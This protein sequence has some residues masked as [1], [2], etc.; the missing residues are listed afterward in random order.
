MGALLSGVLPLAV[1]AAVS[2]SLFALQ[3]MVLSG[4]QRRVSRAWAVVV[5]A[6]ATLAFYAALGLTVLENFGGHRRHSSLAAAVDLAAAL[7]LA[8]LAARM[9][10]RHPTAGEVQRRRSGSRLA[11]ASTISC[12]GIGAAAMLVNFSTLVLFLPA[13]REISHSPVGLAQKSLVTLVLVIVTL[14]AAWLP[15]AL[16]V[17]FGRRADPL[18]SGLNRFVG[19]HSRE[20]TAGIELIFCGLLL[21]KAIGRLS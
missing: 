3:V 11:D 20:I 16:V 2:P 7:L 18:L 13:I 15:L 9:L 10:Y 4:S 1:G 19:A 14:V 6:T 5:G 12:V 21:W 8:L 17:A